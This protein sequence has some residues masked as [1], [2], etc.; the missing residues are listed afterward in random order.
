SRHSVAVL[1]TVTRIVNLASTEPV[2]YNP[3]VPTQR[4][5]AL[6]PVAAMPFLLGAACT[7]ESKSQADN[8]A[9]A[10][11]DRAGSDKVG[12]A[13]ITPPPGPV[14]TTPLPG[15]EIDKL[16]K[17]QQDLF[18]KLVASLPSPCGKAHSLRT[19]ITSDQTCKR[20]PF[21]AKLV[22]AMLEDEAKESDV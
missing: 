13:K 10:A 19:S 12:G 2:N 6:I 1:P 7:K 11:L 14:G 16:N 3:T 17:K 5:L 18:Y 15:V 4:I 21:A 9:V 22:E 8:G 20:A